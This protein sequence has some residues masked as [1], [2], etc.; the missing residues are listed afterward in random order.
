ML[1]QHSLLIDNDEPPDF[2]TERMKIQEDGKLSKCGGKKS[3]PF[4][5]ELPS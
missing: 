2:V 4:K 5:N 1:L 3:G